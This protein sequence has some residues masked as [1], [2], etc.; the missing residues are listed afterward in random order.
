[1]N[2][3]SNSWNQRYISKNTG[4]DVGKITQPL[5]EYFD[6]LHSKNIKIFKIIYIININ[7]A[8]AIWRDI[9]AFS[10]NI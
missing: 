6:Q 3:N 9:S 1:M 2:L 8:I 10:H 7:I 4:W 5:K